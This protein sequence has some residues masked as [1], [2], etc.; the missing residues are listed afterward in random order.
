MKDLRDQISAEI[1]KV[2]VGQQSVLNQ[3][4]IA[5]AVGGHALIEGPPGVAKT[6]LATALARSLGVTF[7]RVQFTPDMLPSDLTGTMTVRDGTLTFRPG[8]VFTNILLADEINRTPPKTQAALLEAMQEGQVTVDG[9]SHP[10][11][12]PFLVLATQNPI[13][14]DGTYPL[15]EAQLDR[16]LIKITAGYPDKQQEIALLRM[17]RRG[18]E[19]AAMGTVSPVASADSIENA[20]RSVDGVTVAPDVTAYAAAI[21]RATR[22]QPGVAL[23]ASP[24]AGVHLLAASRAVAAL[25]GRAFVTPDDIAAMALPVLGHRILMRPEAEIE[26]YGPTDVLATILRS[27]PVP[28]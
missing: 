27:I 3:A 7:R 4:L 8:P 1:A 20:M 21:V 17:P 23:G 11:P 16:F 19:L 28:R 10:L 14:F 25:T 5:L 6:M 24:R 13:E 2:S 18:L 9:V 26:G 15:P 12:R 22:D